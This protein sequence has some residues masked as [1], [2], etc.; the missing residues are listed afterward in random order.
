[1]RI[2]RPFDTVIASV[3]PFMVYNIK[4]PAI[5]LNGALTMYGKLTPESAQ[6]WNLMILRRL[7]A[8][9]MKVHNTIARMEAF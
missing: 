6:S 5:D 2:L 3:D 1:M 4:H 7:I 8:W 9:G